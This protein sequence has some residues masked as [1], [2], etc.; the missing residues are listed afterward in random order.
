VTTLLRRA[1]NDR[2]ARAH[3]YA[4]E[5]G[6]SRPV[7]AL[8][9]VL[10]TPLL[11]FWFRLHVSGRENI[12]PEGAAIVAPNH[13]SFLDAFFVGIAIRRHVRYMAKVEL[14]K[15][16]L[17]WLF[18]RLGAFPVRRGEADADALQ[19]AR[20]ILEQG[21]LVVVFPE[22]TRV[23]EPDVLGSPH[24]G[25][26]RLALEAHAPIIPTAIAGTAHLWLGPVPKP[27]RVQVSFLEPVAAA[28]VAPAG[29]ALSLLDRDVWPAVQREYGRLAATPGLVLTVLT[30]LGIGGGLVARRRAQ[31][32]PPRLLG[33]LEPR[34]I[35]RRKKRRLRWPS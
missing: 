26:G 5:K 30:A 11:R 2:A 19:T 33:Q 6:V 22:G 31:S 10:L 16:P 34:R 20:V 7:Y 3:R 21:G 29:D 4:R 13:K 8:A 12:P 35:R 15:G 14:F 25:A 23:E 32:Q 1:G 18:P 24:H 17:A 9:R 27:R 28:E